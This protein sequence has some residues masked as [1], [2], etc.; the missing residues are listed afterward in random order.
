MDDSDSQ[1]QPIFRLTQDAYDVL[2]LA[3]ENNPQLYQD[4]QADFHQALLQ[5]GIGEY[6]EETGIY[7]NRPLTLTPVDIGPRNRSDAQGLDFYRSLVGMTPRLATDGLIWAWMSHFELHA[8]SIARWPRRGNVNP[9][10]HAR[11]HWFVENTGSAL[12]RDNVASRTWWIAHTALKAAEVSGG[13]FTAEQALEHFANHA[14]DYHTVMAGNF[15]RHPLTLAE[16]VRSLL[17]EAEGI[18]NQ[19]L[20]RLWR[21]LNLFTGTRFLELLTREQL[22]ELINDQVEDI[23]SDPELVRDRNKLRNRTPTRVLSLGAGVQSSCLALMAER[24]DYGFPKPDL[25]IFADTGWEPPEVYAHLDWLESQLSFEVV[26]VRASNI[27]DDILNGTNPE[28][29]RFLDIPAFLVNEDGSVSIAARQC[30]AH[31]KLNP[32]HRELRSRLEIPYGQRAPKGTYVEMWL[33]ISADEV[34]RQKPSREE[35][36]TNRYPLIEN[37]FTRGQLLNWFNEN[38]PGRYLPRSSCVGCPYRSDSEWKQLKESDPK[39]FQDAVAV[40]WALRNVPTT[41]GAIRGEAYLHRSR[42]PLSDVDFSEVA[43]YDD[44]MLEECEGLCGI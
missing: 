13:A 39:S 20:Y 15:T 43:S 2:R 11:N 28:G 36:I 34:A 10:G 27:K 23:M 26:R 35:W 17:N 31:Y 16:F 8:Y 30:T 7:A 4:P 3:A 33:G 38:Y 29:E 41:R 12:W 32:I 40:D 18:N 6:L 9:I 42:V 22:R 1:K 21:R 14:E 44:Q 25:A 24:G 19:G 5:R 37:N